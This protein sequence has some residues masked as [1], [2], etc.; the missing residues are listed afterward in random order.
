MMVGLSDPGRPGIYSDQ[1]GIRDT[2]GDAWPLRL[3][4]ELR[5]EGKVIVASS[6]SK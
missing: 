6:L 3:Q 2:K 1:A 5:A 4:H